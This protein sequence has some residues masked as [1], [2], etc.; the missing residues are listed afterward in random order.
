MS[1]NP[2]HSLIKWRFQ[3]NDVLYFCM[4]CYEM[5][6]TGDKPAQSLTTTQD[7]KKGKEQEAGLEPSFPAVEDTLEISTVNMTTYEV[8]L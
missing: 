4:V 1:H 2:I 6:W 3:G 7:L 8:W 5:P